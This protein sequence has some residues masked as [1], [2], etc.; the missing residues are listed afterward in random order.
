MYSHTKHILFVLCFDNHVHAVV[1]VDLK[2]NVLYPV[3]SYS[4]R[5]MCHSHCDIYQIVFGLCA[6]VCEINVLERNDIVDD[7]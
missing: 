7:I 6:P 3:R 2:Y 4:I 1:V 5:R